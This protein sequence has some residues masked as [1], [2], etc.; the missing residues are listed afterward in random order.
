MNS[1][2][3]IDKS[4]NM[5]SGIVENEIRRLRKLLPEK[6]KRLSELL[7]EE[8]PKITLSNGIEVAVSIEELKFLAEKLP[9]ALHNKVQVPIIIM[10]DS[11]LGRGAYVVCGSIFEK[12]AIARILGLNPP[13]DGKMVIYTPHVMLLLTKLK[14]LI[15]LIVKPRTVER[16]YTGKNYSANMSR[17]EY[18]RRNVN[19]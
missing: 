1:Y 7:E 2:F 11:D 9:K 12:M 4:Y 3:N 6:K 5:L 17:G 13:I 19:L 16:V 18:E 15:L 8:K 10:K 14:T